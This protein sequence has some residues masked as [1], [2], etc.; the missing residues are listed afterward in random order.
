VTPSTS[1]GNKFFFLLVDDLSRYM[2]VSLMSS[3]DQAMASFMAFK[4][5]A[6]AESRR[7]IRTLHRDRDGEFTAWA[8]INHC[9]EKGIQHHFTAPYTLEQNGVVERRNQ[10]VMGMARSI[11]KAM[12]MSGW[13]WGRRW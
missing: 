13:F 8:F 10:T 2:W 5:Q 4:S 3:K 1:G 12:A 11:L 6:K 7:K 9:T